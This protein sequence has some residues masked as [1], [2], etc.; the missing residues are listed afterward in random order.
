MA[1]AYRTKSFRRFH[2]VMAE[3]SGQSVLSSLESH[4]VPLVQGLADRLAAGMHMLDVALWSR[5][6][7]QPARR[8]ISKKSFHGNG[9]VG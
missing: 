3:D 8:A 7:R 2:A 4:I 1:A 6:D 9:S 5:P